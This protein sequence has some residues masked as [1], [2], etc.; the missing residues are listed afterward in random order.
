MKSNKFLFLVAGVLILALAFSFTLVSTPAEAKTIKLRIAHEMPENHPYHLGTLKFGEILKEKTD[1]RIEVV[2]Y[3]SGQLGKQK[4]LA[5]MVAAN[6]LDGC[7]VWQGILEGYDPNVGVICLPF[8]FDN[9]EHTWEVI[10]GEIGQKVLK[11]VE[12]KGIKVVTVF[13]NGLYNIVS[14]VPVKNPED[15][16]GVKL[17]V[18]PSA[19]FVET[20]EMLGAVVT[21]MAFGEV[22][23][24]LQLG[25][26]DAEIQGPINVRKSKHFE[27][28]K[29]TCA[30]NMAFLL[31]PLLMSAKKFYSL[32][33]EDQKALLE[34]AHEAAVWQRQNAEEA[35][36]VDTKFLKENGMEYYYPDIELWKAA[37][38]PMYDKHP[39]W[40]ET[41]D[42]IK[43][44]SKK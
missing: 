11:P 29:Y 9:W 43:A 19:V 4:Q 38:M 25:A 22:Y 44:L 17:R 34:A 10:D 14:R 18:Q 42:Q 36:V 20:G 21:P 26:V 16:K 41:I 6:Q 13:N 15:M 28:A 24:A 7:L 35:D 1:G 8:I 33:E 37:M 31:E 40:K 2:V 39:E 27:V 23:S 12:E 32:S 3:P 30:N 5:E